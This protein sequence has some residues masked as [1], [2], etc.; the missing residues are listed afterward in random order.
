MSPFV[1][2]SSSVSPA[3]GFGQ[4]WQVT[5][6]FLTPSAEEF[7]GY[8]ND[9][10]GDD[11]E[12]PMQGPFTERHVGG[13]RHRHTDLNEGSDTKTTRA[14]AWRLANAN[15]DRTTFDE[16]DGDTALS[17]RGI[18][19]HPQYRR[20][21]AAKRPVNIANIKHRTGSLGTVAMGNHSASYEIVQ[22]TGRT[23][24]NSA[25][26]KAEGTRD[27]FTISVAG[28]DEVGY[29][30]HVTDYAKPTRRK[31]SHVIVNR[32]SAPGSPETAG[33]S[34]GG[35]GLDFEAAELSP[36]NNLNYRNTSVRDPLR[37]LL[38]DHTAFGGVESGSVVSELNYTDVT[39]S[40]HKVNRN[41]LH[42]L[43]GYDTGSD[44]PVTGTVFDNYFVQHMIP[45]SDFQYSWVTASTDRFDAALGAANNIYGYFP[46]DGLARVSSSANGFRYESA[47]NFVSSSEIGSSNPTAVPATRQPKGINSAGVVA[48]SFVP[49]DFAG[50]NSNIIEPISASDFT[51]GYALGV[52]SIN[53]YNFG[54]LGKFPGYATAKGGGFITRVNDNNF[55]RAILPHL[56]THRGSNFGH[57]T[58]KQIRVGQTKLVRHYR[59]N[60]LYTH[61]R[62][63][64]T[65]QTDTL[66]SAGTSFKQA[67][68]TTT[69]LTTQSVVS[70]RYYPVVYNLEV[71]NDQQ[72]SKILKSTDVIVK[73]SFVNDIINFDNIELNNVVIDENIAKRATG[74]NK[75]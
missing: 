21:G 36:Y 52:D 73:T 32:F 68:T 31:T 22:T 60:N 4:Q 49:T 34:Q 63:S 41:S 67:G 33:D 50:I 46:Y 54:A 19:T 23:Q 39:A 47:V 25:F 42:R 15:I 71:R 58:W 64:L 38:V 20:D 9:S 51:T 8:H 6:L 75:L 74:P 3:N 29:I 14:E 57:P 13:N 24:N 12:I 16:A 66:N 2:Y 56:L 69:I 62:D 5:D 53:Y 45:R 10:Y 55:S 65:D 48:G 30:D 70:D 7:A 43:E 59:K 72:D 35:P 61:T 40:F 27:N 17:G 37:K 1:P 11:Y 26:V 44:A 28:A 18:S